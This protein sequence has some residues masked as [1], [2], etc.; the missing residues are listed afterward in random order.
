MKK[1]FLETYGG[2]CNFYQVRL[3]KMLII[4]IFK[5][6]NCVISEFPPKPS[7]NRKKFIQHSA[8]LLAAT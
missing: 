7:K 8:T 5:A 6:T 4:N 2:K 3:V 1:R